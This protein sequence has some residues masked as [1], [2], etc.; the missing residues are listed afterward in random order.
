MKN[1]TFLLLVSLGFFLQ[2]CSKDDDTT[3]S[4]EIVLYQTNF[5]QN[6]GQWWE[7]SNATGS[8]SFNNGQYW[9]TSISSV[10]NKSTIGAVFSAATGTTAVETSIK[11]ELL[12]NQTN[13]GEGGIIFNH[14]GNGSNYSY[15]GFFIAYDGYWCINKYNSVTQNWTPYADWTLSGVVRKNDF[16]K[17]RIE[18]ASDKIRF[19]INGTEVYSMTTTSDLTLDQTGLWADAYSRIKADYFKA[20]ELK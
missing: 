20:I 3:S 6:D 9:L 12:N 5:D 1:I 8:G 7:G 19:Y 10:T 11:P 18:R 2:S 13:Y 4:K 17:L 15:I 16:N 14:K